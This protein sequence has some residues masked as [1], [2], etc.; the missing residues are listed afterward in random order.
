VPVARMH[1]CWRIQQALNGA[2]STAFVAMGIDEFTWM[3]LAAVEH[4]EQAEQPRSAELNE[5]VRHGKVA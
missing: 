4:M 3:A 5:N 1:L 2:R